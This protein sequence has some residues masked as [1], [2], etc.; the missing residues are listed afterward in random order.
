MLVN[1]PGNQAGLHRE[2]SDDAKNR[3]AILLPLC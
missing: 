2:L 1:Q 3:P